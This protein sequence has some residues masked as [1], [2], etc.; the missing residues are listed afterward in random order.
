MIAPVRRPVAFG[1]RRM[2]AGQMGLAASLVMLVLLFQLLTLRSYI[3]LSEATKYIGLAQNDSEAASDAQRD[4]SRAAVAIERAVEDP[5]QLEI[6]RGHLL[7][8]ERQFRTIEYGELSDAARRRMADA[9]LHRGALLDRLTALE[10]ASTAEVRAARDELRADTDALEGNTKQLSA[11]LQLSFWGAQQRIYDERRSAQQ[12]LLVV[13]GLTTLTAGLLAFWLRRVVRVDFHRAYRLLAAE[14]DQ[15][16]IAQLALGRSEERVR[17]LLEH[18]SDLVMVLDDAAI[19][20]YCT[21]AVDRLT[22]RPTGMVGGQ[23]AELVVEEDCALLWRA[24]DECRTNGGSTTIRELRLRRGEGEPGHFDVSVLDLRHHDAVRGIVLNAADVTERVRHARALAFRA[25]HDELTGLANRSSFHEVLEAHL[26]A[27]RDVAVLF[28]DVD[29]FKS[30]NDRYGHDVGDV[31][32][33]RF[34]ERLRSQLRAEDIAARFGGDEFMLVLAGVGD[35]DTAM[36]RA[37]DVLD[38]VRRPLAIGDHTFSVGTSVGVVLNRGGSV[39]ADELIRR[40][41]AAMYEAKQ[42]GRGRAE[43]F[44]ERRHERMTE[45]AA[46]TRDLAAAP[47]RNELRL[48]YQPVVAIGAAREPDSAPVAG[49][50]ALIRWRRNGVDVAPSTF[51]PMAEDTGAIVGIGEWTLREACYVLGR[52][53]RQAALDG[54]YVAVNLSARQLHDERLVA[55]VRDAARAGEVDPRGLMLELT[56]TAVMS[57]PVAAAKTLRELRELGVR[58]ALDDFGAGYSSLSYLQSL[59]FDVVKL[60]RSFLVNIVDERGARML[61]SVVSLAHDLGMSVT[62][63]GVEDRAQWDLVVTAGCDHVQGYIVG[64]PDT[65]EQFRRSVEQPSRVPSP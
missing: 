41:D 4:A 6:A 52:W 34:A 61:R 15:R 7:Y 1:P 63:E 29:R 11:E 26:A 55:A 14:S 23:V 18:S 22:A 36:R 37:R 16:A 50:E 42:Q 47:M 35:E 24:I 60:D 49:A 2:S 31:L 13:A 62:A 30:I 54:L 53:Q 19:V 43:L 39:H 33:Q 21:P 56:E 10:G 57:D 12:V 32:L 28:L 58:L 51:I 20:T 45:R 25:E 48:A 38:A 59:P 17:A 8:L 3:G 64:R 27:G 46:F 5:A 40:A 65:P 9:R 44:D